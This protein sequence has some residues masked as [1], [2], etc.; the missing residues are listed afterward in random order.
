VRRDSALGRAPLNPW[1]TPSALD[2]RPAA[3]RCLPRQKATSYTVNAQLVHLPIHASWLNQI[4]IYF[5]VV[6]R[7]LLDP[8]DFTDLDDLQKRLLA[9]PHRY[10][11]NATPF[12]WTFTRQD[13][14]KL[15]LR[16]DEKDRLRPAA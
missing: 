16:L 4:E 3:L 6:Q 7:K 1:A 11:Q 10:E 14:A 12:E 2:L 9:F 5:S 13:L 15:L 8:N